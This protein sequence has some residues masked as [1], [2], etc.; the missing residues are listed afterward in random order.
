MVSAHKKINPWVWVAVVFAVCAVVYG[1]LS[2]YP[3]EMAVYSDELRYL[4][5]ARSLWQGRGLRVRNMPSDYQKILYPLFILPALA[6]KTTAAQ[7]TAIGWLNALYASSAVF[8]AYALCRAT[9]QNRR[10][11]VFLIGAVALLPTMSAASTFMSET[12]FLPLS[13]WQI[14]FLLRAMQAM[15]KARVGWCAAA[16]VWCYLLY[17]NKEVALY[18]LIAWVLVRAWVLWQDRSSWRAELACN[19]ALFGSFAACFVLAKLT[20][21][22]GLGNSYNQTGWL[23]AEQWGFLPFAIVCDV[24]FTVLAF[25]VFPVLLP[26]VGLRRPAKGSDPV[27]TQLPLFLLLSLFVGV[28]VIAWSITVR[29]DL[30][31]PSPRQHMRYLEPL[32]MPLLLVTLNTLDEKLSTT[33]RRLLAVLTAAWGVGFIVLCRA[34]GAGAGDNTLLQ[35]FDFVA[36]RLDRLPVLG[37]NGWLLVWRCIIAVGAACIGVLLLRHKARRAMAC[38]VLA[39]CVLCYAGEWRINRWTYAVTPEAQQAASDLNG[40]LHGLDGTVLFIP[41]GIRQRDSQLIE[42]Y[43]D[44]D[45]YIVEYETL[46]R[47]GLLD[48]DVLDLTAEAPAPEYPG[49]PYEDLTHADWLLVSDDVPLD[50][51]NLTPAD[52]A[53]PA[54]YT[55]WHNNEVTRVAFL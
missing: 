42:T 23:S 35:W 31:S 7:I 24:L 11:T 36:D 33:R 26:A 8:P 39:L 22:R 20:L 13:L 21:F 43:V 25:G 16:G 51:T 2:S 18:Y 3:R 4:D 47:T 41:N 5:V 19:A 55:L 46:C 30:H 10:R 29:E 17:L 52:I 34:I 32:F 53:C 37:L 27:R 12:V 15:P 40:R 49:R 38:G 1:V 9:G 28:G 14:Y 6:L 45:L 50:T 54:G 44:R 48:D